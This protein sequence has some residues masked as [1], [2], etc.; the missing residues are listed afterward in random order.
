MSQPRERLQVRL[1]AARAAP[2]VLGSR[3]E[4]PL[5][6]TRQF[7]VFAL[8]PRHKRILVAMPKRVTTSAEKS[9]SRRTSRLTLGILH[10][11]MR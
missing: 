5:R 11:R 1:L 10:A 2:A 9:S 3:L 4:P 7:G 6:S 8:E